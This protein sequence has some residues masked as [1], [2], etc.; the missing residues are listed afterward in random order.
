MIVLCFIVCCYSHAVLTFSFSK[1]EYS[2][3]E[4]DEDG[5]VGSVVDICV[6]QESSNVELD[7]D[8]TFYV[9]AEDGTATGE[10]IVWILLTF[11][12]GKLSPCSLT[13]FPPM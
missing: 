7:R 6:L 9:T 5:T 13:H 2:M 11:S 12:F 1:S 10:C 3:I 8:F 4:D